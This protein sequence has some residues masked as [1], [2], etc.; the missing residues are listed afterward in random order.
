MNVPVIA[1]IRPADDPDRPQVCSS[2]SAAGLDDRSWLSQTRN[3]VRAHAGGIGFDHL[4]RT[5]ANHT[6]AAPAQQALLSGMIRGSPSLFCL[7]QSG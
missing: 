7:R 2:P 5:P 3:G 4:G 6:I 1:Q